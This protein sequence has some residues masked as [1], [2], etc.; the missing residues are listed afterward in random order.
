MK[1]IKDYFDRLMILKHLTKEAWQA[2]K[3]LKLDE[4]LCC[5][6]QDCYCE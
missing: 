5:D 1:K 6:G 2:V 3:N 4:P